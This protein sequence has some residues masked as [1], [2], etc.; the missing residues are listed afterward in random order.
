MMDVNVRTVMGQAIIFKPNKNLMEVIVM[1]TT[2]NI[3]DF[4]KAIRYLIWKSRLST[5]INYTEFFELCTQIAED[6]EM[7]EKYAKLNDKAM[8]LLLN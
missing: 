1:N 3:S 8:E 7:A 4:E 2:S 6:E 5:D